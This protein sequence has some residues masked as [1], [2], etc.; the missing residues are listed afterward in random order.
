MELRHLRYFLAVAEELHFG[1]AAEVLGIAQPPLSQQI[2]DLEREIGVVLFDR[3]NRSVRLTTAGIAFRTYAIES[4]EKSRQAVT[5]AQRAQGGEEGVLR[6]GFAGTV[7]YTWIP[8]AILAFCK[9]YPKINL[10]LNEL[11]TSE[12]FAALLSD[13]IDVGI[14]RTDDARHLQLSVQ[15]VFREPFQV[16]VAQGHPFTKDPTLSLSELNDQ[17]FIMYPRDTGPGLYEQIRLACRSAGFEMNVA[18]YASQIPTILSF[19]AVGQGIAIVPQCVTTVRWKGV[20][21]KPLRRTSVDSVVGLARRADSKN[22]ISENFVDGLM[23]W[24]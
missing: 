21:F 7:S 19:V 12:Q 10:V 4:L 8:S 9:A 6:V 14:V 22:P 3:N 17:S 24:Q 20:K 13:Q 15:V 5:A 23:R 18:Q 2:K 16:A 1:R 11:R